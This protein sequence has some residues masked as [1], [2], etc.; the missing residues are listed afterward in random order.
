MTKY[1]ETQHLIFTEAFQIL[2][3]VCLTWAITNTFNTFYNSATEQAEPI[4]QRVEYIADRIAKKN[5]TAPAHRIAEAIVKSA[6]AE[7][8]DPFFVATIVE[9]E[10]RYH[11]MATGL[12]GEKG[13][14]QMSKDAGDRCGLDWDNAY[15][16]EANISAGTCYLAIHMRTYRGHMERAA[17]RY[18]GGG[19]PQYVSKVNMRYA[20]MVRTAPVKLTITV[21]A[22]DTLSLLAKRYMGDMNSWPVIAKLNNIED[23][24]KIVV[25]QVIKIPGHTQSI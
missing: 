6:D 23:A 13:L 10:S 12:A 2:F 20:S 4:D 18:N 9:V 25:G 3:V 14:M 11:V 19:D 8:I 5:K 15:N 17:Y 1:N 24:S 22:G 16:L 21:A 7:G